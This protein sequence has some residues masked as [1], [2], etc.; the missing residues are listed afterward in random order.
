MKLNKKKVF[1]LALAVCLIATLSLGSLAWFTDSDSVANEFFVAG[2]EDQNPDDVFS[3]DVWEDSTPADAVGEGKIQDGIQYRDILPGDDLYK[4]VNIENTGAYA[5]YIRATV[6]VTDA[7]VW[8]KINDEI[9]VPLN[10]IADDLNPAFATYR[11]VYDAKLDTLTYILYYNDILPFEG[12]DIVTLFTNIHIPETMD[13]EQAAQMA[14]GFDIKVVAEAVQTKNVGV[15]AVE[16]FKTVGMAVEAGEYTINITSGNVVNVLDI[17]AKSEDAEVAL[18]LNGEAIEQAVL[19]RGTLN[20]A[21]GTI[22]NDGVGLENY[23]EVALTDVKMEAGSSADYSN[24]TF[25]ADAETTYNNVEIVSAGGGIAAAGGAKVVF[26]GGSLEVNTT[27]TSGRY[28]F[29]AEGEGAEIEIN[30]GNFADFTKTTQNQ[31]RAYV[32]AGAGTKVTINGGT[33]GKASTRSGYTAG[34]LGA[35]TVVITGGTFGF[36]PTNWVASGYVANYDS[37]AKTWTVV[38]E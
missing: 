21:D 37:T 33:F 24:I 3:V 9:Y 38:A 14:G 27:S 28:L 16:A 2:S 11:I 15:N 31:K 22:E 7:H 4:E 23:G 19:N 35:G 5:Q 13:R 34:I 6:T 20:I 17:L 1:A 36:D 12:N 26:N 32:Y 29:Y 30:G 10:K 8:Q 25:G 18:D